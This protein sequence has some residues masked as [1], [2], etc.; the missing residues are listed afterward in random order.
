M[1][2]QAVQGGLHQVPRRDELCR[3][4]DDL[5]FFGF[6]FNCGRIFPVRWT[7]REGGEGRGGGERGEKGQKG[8]EGGKHI[9]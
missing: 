1:D 3:L 2:L 9:Q 4:Y 6:E 7:G 5:F 8:A